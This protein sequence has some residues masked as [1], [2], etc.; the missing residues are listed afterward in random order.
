MIKTEGIHYRD[1]TRSCGYY[2]KIDNKLYFRNFDD[3]CFYFKEKTLERWTKDK[4]V[5]H[6]FSP[7]KIDGKY[8]ALGGM[9]DWK[10]DPKWRGIT[11]E[12]F[13]VMY[14]DHFNKPYIRSEEFYKE[15]KY[16]FNTTPVSPFCRGLYLWTSDNGLKWNL[17]GDD[18]VI[19]VKNVGFNSSLAWKSA[20]F[21]SKIC[22]VKRY[23][24]YWIYLRNNIDADRRTIQCTKTTDF[25]NFEPFVTLDLPFDVIFDNYYFC[26]IFQYKRKMFGFFPYYN[27]FYCSIRFM[28]SD[29]GVKW[30]VVSDLFKSFPFVIEHG[31]RKNRDH[32]VSGIEEGPNDFIFYVHHNYMGYDINQDVYLNKYS[33][34]KRYLKEL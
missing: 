19:T 24:H 15:I 32:I 13:K 1:K 6:N 11:Y 17:Q 21:D 29:D 25:V 4:C 7:Y 3:E 20:E 27:D 28:M 30:E 22:I 18:P 34:S 31:K 2:S 26:E 10:K 23:N 16:K 12:E 9:D 33:I 8:V 14:Q 5:S